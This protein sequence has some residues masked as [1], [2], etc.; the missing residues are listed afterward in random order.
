[1]SVLD[2][3]QRD[4]E[5][6]ARPRPSEGTQLPAG[7]GDVYAAA[8]A[9]A[10]AFG[11]TTNFLNRRTAAAA[12]YATEMEKATGDPSLRATLATG[13]LDALNKRLIALSADNPH[14]DIKP[15]TSEDLDRRGL[16]IGTA[17]HLT[18]AEMAQ[19]EKTI[20]GKIG[21]ALGTMVGMSVDPL[22]LVAMPLAPAEG[23]GLL[24]TSL[25]WGAI[26]GMT[27]T[28]N[29][30]IGLPGRE[31]VQ[32]G[33]E[34][35]G[36]PLINIGEAA[37]VGGV[38][39]GG[40]KGLGMLWT[41]AKTGAWPQ[42][43]RDAG[44]VIESEG[45]ILST[46]VYPTLEGEVA[47]RTALQESIENLVNGRPIN[48]DREITPSILGAYEARLGPVMEARAKAI[49]ADEAAFAIEREGA[50]L[51]PPMERLSEVQLGDFRTATRQVEAAAMEQRSK[52][53][54]EQLGLTGEH[55]AL[56]QRVEV[57][58]TLRAD[59]EAMR[60]EIGA[61]RSRIA[62]ARP[63]IDEVTQGRL[64][65]IDAELKG[66]I[67]AERRSVLEGERSSI[68]ETLA[69]TGPEDRRLVAS[70]EAEARGL[71]RAAAKKERDLARL[72]QKITK[73]TEGLAARQ[74]ALP[75]REARVG[76]RV[77]AAREAATG[78]LRKAVGRLAK[79]GYGLRLPREEA[80][81]IA[82]RI[83]GATDEEAPVIL[84]AI[85]E[86]LVDRAQAARAAAPEPQ[87]PFG[88]PKPTEQQRARAEFHTEEMRKGIT[89]LARE[90]GAELP[91]EDAA[92]IA[93]A[94]RGAKS[95]TEALAILDE[96]MLRPR[97]LA[98][99]LPGT[100]AA[101]QL[102][103]L[104]PEE[105]P[106][107]VPTEMREAM[108]PE[109]TPA[110]AAELR[111]DPEV[112]DAMLRDLDRLRAEKGDISIPMGE[113]IDAAGERVAV[114]RTVDSILAEADSRELAAREIAA[115]V[116][117]QEAVG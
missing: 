74:A 102:R 44:N 97:T 1:M 51:P 107:I 117:P 96:L 24:A 37:L 42:S 116:G 46:N 103:A 92:A 12:D 80:E 89:A 112:N 98:E 70:L 72:D 84:R 47:H 75:V 16:E 115:C 25:R 68:T 30:V 83:M 77:A 81:A 22:N 17:V 39:G 91:R 31:Q 85:T 99:T 93:T 14:L 57:R 95:E 94:L 26:T 79:D 73:A 40:I 110:R 6:S 29:E 111:A 114:T 45:N 21:G 3:F 87:L 11:Q 55:A 20:G 86:E 60:T 50:R 76:E 33:Y 109:L 8:A 49:G 54:A 52:I 41:R 18:A 82:Q 7:F 106:S 32:P 100:G 4:H 78:A 90:V 2:L 38:L 27:Q 113:T 56:A 13:G 5:V 10:V 104:A 28:A 19:R 105:A 61:V 35:T 43:V 69:K 88:T 101:R 9:D 65:A 23:L 58:D 67:S 53:A 48:V 71:E 62:Q 108:A 36:A 34:A 66:Q 63:A 64:A 15:L 59:V